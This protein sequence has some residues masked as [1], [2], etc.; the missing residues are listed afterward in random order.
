MLVAMVNHTHGG[1]VMNTTKGLSVTAVIGLAVLAA[2]AANAKPAD[3]APAV[4]ASVTVTLAALPREAAG[5]NALIASFEHAYPNIHIQPTYFRPT[6]PSGQVAA[7]ASAG[8]LQTGSTLAD[9]ERNGLKAGTASDIL[10]LSVGGAGFADLPTPWQLGP[11][12]L[13]DLSGRKWVKQ[14]WNPLVPLVSVAGKIYAEP[15]L[16]DVPSVIYNKDVFARLGLTPPTTFSALLGDCNRIADQGIT[17]IEFAGGD[18]V[19]VGNIVS[20][21]AANTV[22]TADP[23]WPVKRAAGKVT[24]R[25]TLGWRQALQSLL[26]MKSARCF[27]PNPERMTTQPPAYDAFNAGQAAMVTGTINESVVNHTSSGVSYGLFPF[28][29]ASPK[30]TRVLVNP[31]NNLAVNAASPVK[32]SALTFLDFLGRAWQGVAFANTAGSISTLDIAKGVVP[33]HLSLFSPY[34]KTKLVDVA[35]LAWANNPAGV[36]ALRT[37]I[38]GLLAGTKSIDDVLAAADAAW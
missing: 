37:G 1:A 35:P 17:P 19:S 3:N 11:R 2:G 33:S 13:A 10:E 7:Q 30:S 6:P 28:P 21:I 15:L 38:I 24:F 12:Y 5:L 25:G 32:G 4:T 23:S 34:F 14:L 8:Q 26:D 31:V 29:G 27:Q 36:A 16:N 22:Y 9:V 20:A 18:Q